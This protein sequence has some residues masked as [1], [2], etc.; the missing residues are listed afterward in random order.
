MNLTVVLPILVPFATAIACLFFWRLPWVQ[1]LLALLGS[2]ALLG[3]GGLLFLDV[4]THSVLSVQM[5]G[6]IAPFG[7]TMIADRFSAIM[8][9]LNGIVAFSGMIY[10]LGSIDR[11]RE[12]FGFYPLMSV[13]FGAVSGAFLTGDV[14]NM[15][16]WYEVMLM[17]SFVLLALGGERP[18]L[19]SAI[20]YVTLNLLS[21]TLFLVGVGVLYGFAGTLNF[22]D[23]GVKLA[24]TERPELVTVTAMMFLCAFGIKAAAFPFF[25]WLPASYHTPPPV[26]SAVFAGML[27]KVG[28]YSIVRMFSLVFTQEMLLT[29]TI[30]LW[31]GA[32][33]MLTGVLGAASQTD[34]R[35]ILSFHIISQIGYMLI[36]VGIAGVGIGLAETLSNEGGGDAE[37]MDLLMSG[38]GIALAGSIFYILHHIIV[39]TNLFFVAGAIKKL[40]NTEEL[41]GVGGLYHARPMLGLLFMIPAMSL[42][43]IPILSGFWAKLALVRAGLQVGT[44]T[45]VGIAL[46]VG[47]LTLYSMTKIWANGFWAAPPGTPD[48]ERGHDPGDDTDPKGYRVMLIP[49]VGMAAITLCLGL[50]AGPAFGIAQRAAD[51]LLGDRAHIRALWE[52]A[53]DEARL[54]ELL[55]ERNYVNTVLGEEY[56]RSLITEKGGAR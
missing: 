52:S 18:Q 3:C 26:V 6:W 51:Q 19:E 33:T 54:D 34:I 46:F 22:A 10:A 40:R 17:A 48:G 37:R 4:Q 1:R 35:R 27:T 21:S 29:H 45:V 8:V 20:K 24:Q 14:F 9:L 25:F 31:M 44:Y 49:I 55:Q 39:K 30:I 7:I 32:L 12:R 53:Q 28:V 47:L 23:L 36:G 42:A 5:S 2:G 16:V 13:L 43:G 11:D 56:L 38:A 15:Y 41:D 50:F